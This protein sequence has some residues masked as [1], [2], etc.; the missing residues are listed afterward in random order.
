VILDM[1]GVQP[2]QRT[3]PIGSINVNLSRGVHLVRAIP[4]EERVTFERHVT[5]SVPVR[6]RF[7][8]EGV[9]GYIVSSQVE[10]KELTIAGPAS[11]VEAVTEAVTDP[12][13]VSNAV[14]PSEYH[15]NAF[16]A[17]PYVRFLSSPQVTVSVAMKSK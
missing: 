3:F 8:G 5:R 11:R 13:D 2:G 10:P 14:G 6:A 15:A 7:V 16:V 17:D 12:V 9:H 1:S 4:S